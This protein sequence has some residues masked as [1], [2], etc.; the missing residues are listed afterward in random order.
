LDQINI[1]RGETFESLVKRHQFVFAVKQ[2]MHQKQEV[3]EA[4]IGNGA[5]RYQ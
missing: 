2:W 4:T 1:R 3:G 5:C